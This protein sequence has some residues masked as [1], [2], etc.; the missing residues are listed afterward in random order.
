MFNKKNDVRKL[1]LAAIEGK[2]QSAQVELERREGEIEEE[3][4]TR[5]EEL[6][7][8]AKTKKEKAVAEAV[9]SIIGKII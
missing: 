7:V 2:I 6:R 4:L 8:E 1:V 3:L 5:L 9:N